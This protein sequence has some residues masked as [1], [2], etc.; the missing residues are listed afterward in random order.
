MKFNNFV[1]TLGM[2]IPFYL[3][4]ISAH[5]QVSEEELAALLNESREASSTEQQ[6]PDNDIVIEEI[7]SNDLFAEL[8]QQQVVL[9][10]LRRQIEIEEA[11]KQLR[12]LTGDANPNNSSAT[13][14]EIREL[15]R[16]VLFLR[17][18]LENLVNNRQVERDN[19]EINR[20]NASQPINWVAES[21]TITGQQRSAIIR[22]DTGQVFMAHEGDTLGDFRIAKIHPDHVLVLRDGQQHRVPRQAIDYQ[23]S[24]ANGEREGQ[25]N[26]EEYR[27]ENKSI[28]S[29]AP[30]LTDFERT[31]STP[32]DQ[33]GNPIRDST[34]AR[35][36]TL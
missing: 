26:N 16:E 32:I 23:P 6:S 3:V 20:I 5:A 19:M 30:A 22:T 18:S 10:Q 9:R 29:N 35:L 31:Y 8:D 2:A 17:N 27:Q 36:D 7:N 13:E 1:M 14:D 11:R 24:S 25:A 12:E 28:Q 15:R 34:S 33:N 21:L 4:G